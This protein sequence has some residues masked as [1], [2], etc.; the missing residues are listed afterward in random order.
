MKQRVVLLTLACVCGFW[1]QATPLDDLIQGLTGNDEVARSTARQLLVREGGAALPRVLPLLTHEDARIWWAA[2]NVLTEI[3]GQVSVPGREAE[4]QVLTDGL[5]ALLAPEQPANF[6]ICALRLLPLATPEG[7]AVE[8]IAKLLADTD[9]DLREKARETLETIRTTQAAEALCNALDAAD[10]A[11]QSALLISL[12]QIKKPFCL[13]KAASLVSSADARVRASAALAL[14]CTGNTVYIPLMKNVW[15]SSDAATSFDACDALLRFADAIVMHGGNF[16]TAMGL[17]REV[18]ANDNNVVHQSGAIAGLGRYGD[19]SAVPVILEALKSANGRELEPA[20]LAAFASLQGVNADNALLDAYAEASQ[21]MKIGMVAAFGR[22]QDA[23][24]LPLLA[25]AAQD[26]DPALHKAGINA[27]ADSRQAA[28]LDGLLANAQSDH[29]EYKE[30]AVTGLKRLA[31]LYRQQNEKEAAGKAFLALYRAA[32]NDEDKQAAFDGIK[33]FPIPEAFDVVMNS[34]SPEEMDKLPV[35]AL[36]GLVKGMQDAGRADDANKLMARLMAR[37]NTPDAVR[38]AIA[39]L[40]QMGPA[41]EAAHKLGFVNH[42]MIAGPFPWSMANAFNVINVNEPNVDPKAMYR[43]DNKD[44]A[45]QAHETGDAGGVVNLSAVCPGDHVCAYAYTQIS[46]PAEADAVVRTGSDD[47]IK[48]W[49]NGQAVIE[50]NVDRPCDV[51][52]DQ[53]AVK[54]NAG[55]NTILVECTQN[56]GGWNFRLRLTTPD[57]AALPFD[58][59][60]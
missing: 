34:M 6:K 49:V 42:W 16:D 41:V 50:Q 7:C 20:A 59:V 15:K 57:G 4:R 14:A 45:W 24:F 47:G 53:G 44:M 54:L 8:P 26:A 19:E 9:A 1:A 21:D 37:L 35:A 30:L 17:Y 33:Q 43:L 18:L 12:S 52:Q 48:V 28:A 32:A 39:V 2:N 58:I 29:A 51:D 10:P 11:F 5:M 60:K 56:G 36:V 46:V 38:Q 3:A 25:A 23:A 31:Q 40:G 55:V 27:L 13:D 22:K